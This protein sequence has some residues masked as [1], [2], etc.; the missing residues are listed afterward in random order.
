[1]ETQQEALKQLDSEMQ[2]I[3]V[4]MRRASSKKNRDQDRENFDDLRQYMDGQDEYSRL[5]TSEVDQ[6]QCE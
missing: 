2:D 3:Q 5:I 1:M 6:I 4:V